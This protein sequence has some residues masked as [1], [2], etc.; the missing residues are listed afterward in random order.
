MPLSG[1]TVVVAVAKEVLKL[2]FGGFRVSNLSKRPASEWVIVRFIVWPA[3]SFFEEPSTVWSSSL[4][5][6]DGKPFWD[7]VISTRA[8]LMDGFW[9]KS[10]KHLSLSWNVKM[11]FLILASSFTV[12]MQLRKIAKPS[13]EC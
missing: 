2:R 12:S 8:S 6:P 5:I 1:R 10:S 3:A 13:V 7:K 4:I 9:Q 11:L